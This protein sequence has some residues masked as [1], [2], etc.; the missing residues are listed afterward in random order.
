[1]RFKQFARDLQRLLFPLLL[2]WLSL[3]AVQAK[4][5]ITYYHNDALGSP[6]A[7]TDEQ[8]KVIWR[9]EYTPYGERLLREAQDREPMGYTGKPEEVELGLTYFGARWYDPH[10]GRF[11]SPDPVPF[12]E[13]NPHSFN[14]YAYA[15]A[16][17]YRYV[18]PNGESPLDIGFF[19]A[20]A[21]GFGLALASGNPQAIASAGVDLATSTVGLISPVPGTGL[22][23]K[24]ARAADKVGDAAR[25]AKNGISEGTKVYRVWGDQAVPWG[26]S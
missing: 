8:G 16:N 15:N 3:S 25:V 2:G 14:R 23:L 20:D 13:A 11:L 5:I 26:R 7:A 9:E 17:P 18:D 10:L 1:M 6:I 19:V 24:A 4:E 22:A 12:Q 21:I